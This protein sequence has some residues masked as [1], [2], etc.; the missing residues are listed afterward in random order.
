MLSILLLYLALSSFIITFWVCVHV[1]LDWDATCSGLFSYIKDRQLLGVISSFDAED[2]F[3][4]YVQL[5]LVVF[6]TNIVYVICQ[7][8]IIV[9][10]RILQSTQFHVNFSL[11]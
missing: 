11:I 8:K 1:S 6:P 2:N 10:K 7:R 9:G 3:L 4:Q 5:F